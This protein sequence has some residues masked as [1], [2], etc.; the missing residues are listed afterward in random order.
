MTNAILLLVE[1]SL[2]DTGRINYTCP[3]PSKLLLPPVTHHASHMDSSKWRDPRSAAFPRRTHA[4]RIVLLCRGLSKMN[5]KLK[6]SAESCNSC[7]GERFAYK[8]ASRHRGALLH[9]AEPL[10]L[11]HLNGLLG[12]FCTSC[13]QASRTTSLYNA[14][15]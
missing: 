2:C 7:L 10:L 6:P 3:L 14:P 12:R 11:Q 9:Q 5:V 4:A 15:A 1:M 8:P 13:F